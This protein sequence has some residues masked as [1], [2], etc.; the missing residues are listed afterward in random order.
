[1]AT[2]LKAP[3]QK[4]NEL[5]NSVDPDCYDTLDREENSR[6]SLS[7]NISDFLKE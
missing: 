3:K 2:L 7:E 6:V 5:A 4:K 1:M